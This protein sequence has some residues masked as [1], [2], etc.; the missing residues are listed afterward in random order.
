LTLKSATKP[1]GGGGGKND[2][3]KGTGRGQ[4]I[5]EVNLNIWGTT[6]EKGNDTFSQDRETHPQGVVKSL[7]LEEGNL[8]NKRPPPKGKKKLG[9]T[10][11][12]PLQVIKS[13]Q[14]GRPLFSGKLE[15]PAKNSKSPQGPSQRYRG[16]S[17]GQLGGGGAERSI[18]TAR[19]EEKKRNVVSKSRV[20]GSKTP[21]SSQG[22]DWGNSPFFKKSPR[23]SSR[24]IGTSGPVDG[25][26]GFE[27]GR[28][29]K[30]QAPA[31]VETRK[32]GEGQKQRK[33]RPQ[34]NRIFT[35]S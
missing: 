32:G 14:V 4:K 24:R 22:Q 20:Q 10:A 6:L 21:P 9:N 5:G 3:C 8:E 27:T 23:E 15:K 31:A 33:V 17:G 13:P 34:Q 1:R 18:I 19:V 11:P 29:K 7:P 26:Y 16:E 30:P 2:T 35:E 25:R 12:L 28:E